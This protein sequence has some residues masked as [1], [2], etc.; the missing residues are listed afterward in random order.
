[1]C[2][3][4]PRRF[5]VVW[6]CEPLVSLSAP[7]SNIPVS[8]PFDRQPMRITQSTSTG[9]IKAESLE[10]P[11]TSLPGH[12][13]HIGQGP[14]RACVC[15]LVSAGLRVREVGESPYCTG[16]HPGS[17][18]LDSTQSHCPVMSDTSSLQHPPFLTLP[19]PP[20]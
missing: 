4:R 8:L 13:H 11:P 1:V 9:G 20:A 19:L 5:S 15:I 10:V 12:V 14:L 16:W 17:Y 7:L 18:S 3:L 6:L 2:T